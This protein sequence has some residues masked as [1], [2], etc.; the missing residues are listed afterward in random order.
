[1]KKQ[2]SSE[3]LIEFFEQGATTKV[4]VTQDGF[5]S[6]ESCRTISQGTNDSLD[7]LYSLL[8][9]TARIRPALTEPA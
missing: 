9:T 1:M 4:V 5:D 7:E 8:C 6:T 3:E 2:L